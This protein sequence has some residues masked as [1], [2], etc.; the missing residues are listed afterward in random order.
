MAQYYMSV[1]VNVGLNVFLSLPD[2]AHVALL[3]LTVSNAG[4][5]IE[6]PVLKKSNKRIM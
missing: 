2:F 5:P 1:D 6:N 3:V 4:N